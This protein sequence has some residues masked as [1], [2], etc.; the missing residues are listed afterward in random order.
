MNKIIVFFKLV[1]Q[2]KKLLFPV[3][4]D[5]STNRLI[6]NFISCIKILARSLDKSTKV[7]Q[8]SILKMTRNI[9]LTLVT[10]LVTLL[11]TLSPKQHAK[12]II[13]TLTTTN[14]QCQMINLLQCVKSAQVK[15]KLCYI[16]IHLHDS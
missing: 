1:F 11:L 7:A 8:L 12:M 9:S 2:L 14:P 16:M 10:A 13:V 4:I 6:Q 5:R 15:Y 3:F